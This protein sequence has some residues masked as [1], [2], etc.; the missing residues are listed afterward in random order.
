MLKSLNDISDDLLL[1][2]K[3][4]SGC[5]FTEKQI[6]EFLEIDYDFFLQCMDDEDNK[7][8]RAFFEGWMQAEFDLRK[9]ILQLAKAGSSP[10]QTM[11]SNILDKATL[12]RLSK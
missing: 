3:D 5:F 12:K 6:S 1:Q 7:L 2:V 4:L 11:A 10:A 9:C 8:R